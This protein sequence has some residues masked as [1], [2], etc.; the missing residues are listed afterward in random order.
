M[1]NAAI[2]TDV[3]IVGAGPVGP[4]SA[5][6]AAGPETMDCTDPRHDETESPGREHRSSFS[7][8]YLRRSP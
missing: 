7:R 6:L 3:L 8:T 1:P 2:D 5:R 4:V